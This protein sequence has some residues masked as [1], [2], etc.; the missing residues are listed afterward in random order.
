MSVG[1]RAYRAGGG[2]SEVLDVVGSPGWTRTSDILINRRGPV[3]SR[4]SPSFRDLARNRAT[5]LCVR[6]LIARD[7]DVLSRRARTRSHSDSRVV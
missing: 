3:M 2:V 5:C 1:A 6:S 4:P 7:I